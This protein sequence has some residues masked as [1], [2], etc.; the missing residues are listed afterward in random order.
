M[1]GPA[2]FAAALSPDGHQA[3]TGGGSNTFPTNDA[4]LS[5]WDLESGSL[6]RQLAG[7]TGRVTGVAFLPDRRTAISTSLDGTAQLWDLETG[8][9]LRQLDVHVTIP[10][11][12]VS[13]D[14]ATAVMVRGTCPGGIL[15]QWRM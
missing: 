14:G 13:P 4:A 2:I 15:R 3:L 1:P 11:L 6:I 8:R 9:Q 5:L 10:A 12:A 7:H